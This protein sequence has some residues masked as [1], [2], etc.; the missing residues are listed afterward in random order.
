MHTVVSCQFQKSKWH[1]GG[2]KARRELA[3]VG[4]GEGRRVFWEG[5]RTSRPPPLRHSAPRPSTLHEEDST[6][7]HVRRR[8][9]LIPPASIFLS[10]LRIICPLHLCIIH[11]HLYLY[12]LQLSSSFPSLSLQ[13]TRSIRPWVR[14]RNP[15]T[16]RTAHPGPQIL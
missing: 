8:R 13:R 5:Q 16:P 14:D 6:R 9:H 15:P 10:L 12:Y 4:E 11:H 2:G 7:K 1:R 3:G